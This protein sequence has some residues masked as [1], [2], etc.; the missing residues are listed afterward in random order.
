MFTPLETKRRS[1]PPIGRL[2]I[3]NFYGCDLTNDPSNVHPTRSPDCPNMI[4]TTS[5]KVGK[6]PGYHTVKTYDGKINGVHFLEG[7]TTKKL[8][9]AGTKL[10]LDGETPAELYSDMNDKIS[11]SHQLMGKLVIQDGKTMLIYDGTTVKP[12]SD[13]A[14]IPTIV[15]AGTPAGGG[16]PLENRNLVQPKVKYRAAGTT[17]DKI[18]QLPDSA[19]DATAVEVSLLNSS[20]GF[21]VKTEGADF[22]VNRSTGQVTFTTAPGVSPITGEDN[23]YITYSKTIPGNADAI[24][25]TDI[26]ILYGLNGARDRLFVAGSSPNIDYYCQINDPT[27]WGQYWYSVI[28]QDSASIMGYSIINEKL[29]THK[30]KAENDTNT[31]LRKGTLINNE[32]AFVLDGAYQGPGV[33]AK[34]SMGTLEN[35]PLFV[36]S[37]K[38]INAVT[39]SDVLGERYSQQRSYYLNGA[40]KD[41][42]LTDSF[43]YTWKQFYLLAVGEKVYILDGTQFFT[44]K[45]T[46]FSHRQ[47]AGFYWTNIGARVIWSEGDTLY[48]GTADG[49]INA[50]YDGTLRTHYNDNGEPIECYWDTA[51]DTGENFAMKKTYVYI[52]L[53]LGAFVATGVKIFGLIQG[54]WNLLRDYTAEANYLDFNDID[55]SDFSFSTDTTPRTIGQKIKI[56]NV[57]KVQFRFENSRLNQP[58]EL[59]EAYIEF[60]QSGYYRK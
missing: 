51:M 36:S 29:A 28:G 35:E 1:A 9:H 26:S 55:F 49:D 25:K 16:V 22:T 19:I 30:N 38:T 60:I 48:F 32:V 14:Y 41:E 59:Y 50:F 3:E 2:K 47:Y 11:V 27:Y 4:R 31:I 18:F 37:D 57:D 46:P 24:N 10:Y 15:I 6:R 56:K 53:R 44:E 40:L 34:H 43:A 58:F 20:G 21:D 23:I 33:I 8:V 54:I 13:G 7:E 5:G 42:D 17:G 52:G 45:N 39:P 12:I